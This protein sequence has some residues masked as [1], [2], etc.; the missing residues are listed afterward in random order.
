MES[1]V[2]AART[3]GT[4][5]PAVT[6]VCSLVSRTLETVDLVEIDAITYIPSSISDN[7]SACDSFDARDDR[8][9]A[10]DERKKVGRHP[11]VQ[12]NFARANTGS[13]GTFPHSSLASM[14]RSETTQ[15]I[16]QRLSYMTC[17]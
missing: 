17:A 14:H 13:Y 1:G 5:K 16:V 9:P 4:L 7:T 12:T 15:T 3:A 11:G 8:C 6:H 10:S 2:T